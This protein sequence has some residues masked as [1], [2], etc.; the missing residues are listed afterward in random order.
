MSSQHNPKS[1]V[2]LI[3]SGMIAL[4]GTSLNGSMPSQ[5]PIELPAAE[6]P[7]EPRGRVP[8]AL[9]GLELPAPAVQQPARL[10]ALRLLS[11]PS[12]V[13]LAEGA[14]FAV[15]FG[16]FAAMAIDFVARVF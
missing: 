11:P 15:L 3:S 16:G 10:P 4:M 8:A 14:L 5:P 9:L 6:A 2:G 12:P 7:S 1:R 13:T